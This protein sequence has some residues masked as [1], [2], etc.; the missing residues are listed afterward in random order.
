MYCLSTFYPNSFKATTA[1]IV[2]NSQFIY[3]LQPPITN[4]PS[5][6]K[7]DSRKG[8]R[9]VLPG[10]TCPIARKGGSL[11]SIYAW[12]ALKRYHMS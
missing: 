7:L 4:L 11:G 3:L 12:A 8:R 2:I 9:E 5:T 1:K 10:S 6:G